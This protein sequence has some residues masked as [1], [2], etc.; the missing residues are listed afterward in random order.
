MGNP[1]NGSDTDRYLLIQLIFT[2]KRGLG[3]R[4]KKKPAGDADIVN[5]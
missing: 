1:N 5:I 4:E 3:V 2:W